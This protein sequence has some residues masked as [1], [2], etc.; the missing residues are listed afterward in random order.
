ML[1]KEHEDDSLPRIAHPEDDA[2]TTLEVVVTDV[3]QADDGS[4]RVTSDV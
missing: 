4:N 2:G 1:A 3:S